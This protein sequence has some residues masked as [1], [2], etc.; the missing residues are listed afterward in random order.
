M[1]AKVFSAIAVLLTIASVSAADVS[2]TASATPSRAPVL[3]PATAKAIVL[4]APRPEYSFEAR[5]RHL[6]GAGVIA[7]TIDPSSGK[8]TDVRMARNTGSPILDNAVL[9]AFRRWRFKPGNY[10]PHLRMPISH[11]DR[12][13]LL[14]PWLISLMNS[15]N[16][17]HPSGLPSMSRLGSPFHCSPL[18]HYP[19]VRSR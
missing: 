15:C 13:L 4:S 6:T 11:I 5:S 16:F 10:D 18:P 19:K 3:S 9:A 2:A 12:S 7:L 14:R 1:K 8:V 17:V